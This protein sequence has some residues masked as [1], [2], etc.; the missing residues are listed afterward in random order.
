MFLKFKNQ[1]K[2]FQNYFFDFFFS[3]GDFIVHEA[4]HLPLPNLETLE[5]YASG[6]PTEQKLFCPYF[7]SLRNLKFDCMW[8]EGKEGQ[9]GE[10]GRGRK[11]RGNGGQR[12]R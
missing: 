2:F 1:R 7:P 10:G 11:Q 3:N 4:S 9:G 12:A 6:W 5:F 8:K